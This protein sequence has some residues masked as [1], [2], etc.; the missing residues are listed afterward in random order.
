MRIILANKMVREFSQ[1]GSTD[2]REFLVGDALGCEFA[3]FPGGCGKTIHCEECTIRKAI[4]NTF[5]T[6]TSHLKEKALLIRSTPVNTYQIQYLVSTEKV[7]DTVL[8]RIDSTEC[9]EEI[10]V[11]PPNYGRNQGS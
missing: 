2:R 7:R 9:S 10:M 11:E 3:Q 1:R 8:L 6:G 5:K 4:L